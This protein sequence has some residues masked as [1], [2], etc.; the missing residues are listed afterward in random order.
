MALQMLDLRL[1]GCTRRMDSQVVKRRYMDN[2]QVSHQIS[3]TTS[4]R[5]MCPPLSH[6]INLP[7]C[8]D[9]TLDISKDGHQAN[10]NRCP[11]PVMVYI[12]SSRLLHPNITANGRCHPR[13]SCLL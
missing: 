12:M 8:I 2:S 11:L 4:I 3:R 13:T 10:R 9:K 7:R 1:T 6:Q 5:Q